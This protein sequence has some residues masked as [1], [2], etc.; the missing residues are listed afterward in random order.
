MA[1]AGKVS[2][3]STL[4]QSFTAILVSG[5]ENL[6]P[7]LTMTSHFELELHDI[8]HHDSN[9]T[10][11]HLIAT[12]FLVKPHDNVE[13]GRKGDCGSENSIGALN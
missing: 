10:K 5:E 8:C 1:S 9:S 3:V 6:C 13:L 7:R 2:Y 12:F 4:N 11:V